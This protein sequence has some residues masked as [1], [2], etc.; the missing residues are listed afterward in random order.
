MATREVLSI[1]IFIKEKLLFK[2]NKSLKSKSLI[3]QLLSTAYT[4]YRPKPI[5]L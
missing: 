4:A 2:E 1:K 3:H 5:E